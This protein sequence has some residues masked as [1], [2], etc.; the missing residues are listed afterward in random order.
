[1]RYYDI[2][3]LHSKR[4]LC[5]NKY[6]QVDASG[7]II[8]LTQPVPCFEHLYP[9]EKALNIQPPLKYVIFGDEGYRVRCVP[10][11]KSSFVCRYMKSSEFTCG[12]SDL[13]NFECTVIF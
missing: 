11:N 8:V 5:G 3:I 7:E 10:I 6:L 9:I 4:E 1:M 12:M 2:N 13:L